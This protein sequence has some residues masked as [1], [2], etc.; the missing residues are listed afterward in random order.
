M[1]AEDD[2]VDAIEDMPESYIECRGTQHRWVLIEPFRIV[3]TRRENGA[4]P[5]MGE[6]VYARRVLECD[7]CID[8]ET[9]RGA[10]RFDYYRITSH[11]GHT[12]LEKLGSS[13]YKTPKG[14][15][16]KGT[17]RGAGTRGLVLGM[18]LDR[19]MNATRTRGRG[20]PRRGE[21]HDA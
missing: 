12:F 3:D 19:A 13:G 20:R 16:V 17:G 14:Y 7:R 18:A 1:T 5:H 4:H 11:R 10:L 8:E 21:G 15:A 6:Q 2:F 9:G